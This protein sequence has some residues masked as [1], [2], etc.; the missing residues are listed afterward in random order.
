MR[1]EVRVWNK[2]NMMSKQKPEDLIKEK[3]EIELWNGS[4]IK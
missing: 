3:K 1:V 2:V 4:K